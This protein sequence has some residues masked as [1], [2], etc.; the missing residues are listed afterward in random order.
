MKIWI[1]VLLVFCYIA[2]GSF[3][4][5]F[6][7]EMDYDVPYFLG[8]VVWPIT[9]IS[10]SL[11]LLLD[12]ICLVIVRFPSSLGAKMAFVIKKMRGGNK[13]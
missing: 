10:A 11:W 6:L 13:K 5:T 4:G 2:I 3:V 12:G 7:K 8:G 1:I 9:I